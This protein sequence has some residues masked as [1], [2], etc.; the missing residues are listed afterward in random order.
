MLQTLPKWIKNINI[1]LIDEHTQSQ[2]RKWLSKR[3][4]KTL[5]IF[6]ALLTLV[7][8]NVFTASHLIKLF[9][10]FSISV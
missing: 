6:V 3:K 2:Q 4:T 1:I 10:S 9:I 7:I 8:I 5:V